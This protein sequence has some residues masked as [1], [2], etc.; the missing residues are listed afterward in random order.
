MGFCQAVV[1]AECHTH[2]IL[3]MLGNGETGCSIHRLDLRLGSFL[4]CMKH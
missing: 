4:Y 2:F 1:L 3:E